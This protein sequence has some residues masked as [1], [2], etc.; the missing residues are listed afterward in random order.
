MPAQPMLSAIIPCYN[1]EK[2]LQQGV[3]DEVYAYLSTQTYAWEV[4]IVNDES[5]DRSRELIG[6][7]IAD[8]PRFR[9]QDIPHGGKPAAVW[10]GIQ[11][12]RGDR[13][14]FTD[15]DQSTP[16]AAV[17]MLLPGYAA[18]YDGVIG[19]RGMA[20][21][22]N[23]LLRKLGSAVFLNVRRLLLLRNVRD[24]QCGFKSFRREVALEIFPRLQFFKTQ[25]RPKG[26][27]VSAYDVE[28]LFLCELAGYR[29]QEVTV[30]WRNR[31]VS[32]T[33]GQTGELSR[34]LRESAE[35]LCEVLRV[36]LNHLRG[37]YHQL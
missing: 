19:S 20:R 16:I 10:A 11:A 18:G 9:V 12:A 27:K 32:D 5:T 17:E 14:L 37:L 25:E 2:N 4:V 24:T 34:Y 35:M 36:K 21:E 13:V 15:M 6:A 26:W 8:K 29:I 3:L 31:D 22:G 30:P 33:K 23:S 1:E 28:L 7:F